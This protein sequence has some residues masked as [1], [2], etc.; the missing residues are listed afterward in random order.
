ME[1]KLIYYLKKIIEFGVY[2]ILITPLIIGPRYFFPFVGPKSLYFMGLVEIIFFAWLILVIFDHKYL[3]RKN[4]ILWAILFYIG[5]VILSTV[6]GVDPSRSFWSK[7]ER[8]TGLL[9]QLHLFAFFL[10]MSSTF[11]KKVEWT[12]IFLVSILVASF[13]SLLELLPK[14]GVNIFGKLLS[15]TRS[16]ATLGNT[17]FLASYLIFNVFLALYLF[18]DSK[19]KILKYVFGSI[20]IL[21]AVA[22]TYSGGRAAAL[23]FSGALILLFLLWLIFEK[24]GVLRLT[25]IILLI[26]LILGVVALFYLIITPGSFLQQYFIKIANESRFGTAKIAWKAFLVKPWFG[27]GPEN[28]EL[29]FDK[30]FSPHFFNPAY[31]G[32]VWFDRAHNIVFDTLDTLGIVGFLAYL[33][34]FITSFWILAKNYFRKRI[35][36]YFAGIFTVGLIGYFVQNLTVFD[37]VSSYMMF[38]LVLGFLA[39]KNWEHKEGEKL[40]ATIKES[41]GHVFIKVILIIFVLIAFLLSFFEFVIRPRRADVDTIKAMTAPTIKAEISLS[42]KAL[43]DSQLGKYQI[44]DALSSFLYSKVRR[45]IQSKNPTLSKEDMSEALSFS[46]NMTK[47]TIQESPLDYRA[48]LKL[49]QLYSTYALVGSSKDEFNNRLTEAD[50]IAQKA[51]TDFPTNQQGYWALGQVKLYEGKYKDALDLAQKALELEP[52]SPRSHL[53][54]IQVARI[55]GGKKLAEQYAAESLKVLPSLKPSIEKLGL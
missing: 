28:F 44:R 53:I 16:G 45:Q 17:S 2:A 37:M 1:E 34:I 18:F 11:R 35:K 43:A 10:V 32:E 30:Y 26:A 38:I 55:A 50:K 19:E 27:W 14:M 36:F 7:F 41:G 31:G 48:Y 15:A 52:L 49:G 8:M 5:A 20:F 6:V 25:G 23:S 22:L 29:V 21:S 24:K 46:I 3:P 54:L 33:S 13:V 47:E 40:E 51:V 42:K 39:S 12:Q 9:M 4:I